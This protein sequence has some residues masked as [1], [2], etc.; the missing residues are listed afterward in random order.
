FMISGEAGQGVQSVGFI[1]AKAF[2]RGGY[3][4]FADQDY[5]S[6]VRGGESFFRIRVKDTPVAAISEQ[7]DVLIALNK[8]TLDLHW[9]EVASGGVAIFDNEKVSTR[10]DSRLVAIPLAHLAEEK[11]GNKVMANTVAIGAAI[12]LVKFDLG[13][14]NEVLG[15]HYGSGES[16]EQNLIAARAG[17]DYA[18]DKFVARGELLA[19]P[20]GPRRMLLNGNEAI[21]LGA[22][23][24]GC[25]FVSAYPMT[26]T[27]SIIEYLA[28][29]ADSLDLAFVQAE[30]EI[31]A[32]HMIV[33]AGYAG[34]RAMT[35]TAG[36]GFCLMVEG[37]GLAGITETPIV[38]VEGQRPGPAIGL[39]TRTEQGD[40]EFVIHASH[41][42]FP[43]AV[44]APSNPTDAFWLTVKAFNLADKYQLPVVLI[45]DHHLASSY[46][47]TDRFDLS[48]V[49]IDRGLLFS[50]ESAAGTLPYA[51]HRL[52]ESGISPRAFPGQ[53]GVLVATDSD[54]H[55]EAGHL[56]ESGEIRN[57]MM[58]KRMGKLIAL[59]KEMPAPTIYGTD[60][61]KVLLV[62]WGST[63]G[64]IREACDL[65]KAE[66]IE[67]C[68]LH[69]TGLW[70][71]PREVVGGRIASAGRFY[72]IE[73][74]A[75]GQLAHLISAETGCRATGNV[76]KYD[77]RPFTPA[78]IAREIRKEIAK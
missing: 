64:A 36:G 9:P 27:T 46:F 44:L 17:Y 40:L 26:P 51:R 53:S 68:T 72:V 4:V 70:P 63:G 76:L 73:N 58:N 38:V 32:I 29:K 14:L 67:T 37:L 33:G 20:D 47:T 6:R 78:Q 56:T 15:E 1:L 8:D 77:G 54:E 69:L 7:V 22:L 19:Q 10:A 23:A 57:Q 61:A 24:A 49:T 66:G 43:R 11:A 62:G 55:D 34:V 35:A 59:S 31:S 39:P 41:G 45:T 52:T 74:N 75:T 65:L 18:R 3:H 25:K 12:G 2:S 42:E 13:L 60:E 30:D 16:G 5:E 71:F 21:A 48:G 50:N 28:A